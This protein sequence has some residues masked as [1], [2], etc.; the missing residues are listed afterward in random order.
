MSPSNKEFLNNMAQV[1]KGIEGRIAEL[2]NTLR[3][4]V[5]MRDRLDLQHTLQVNKDLLKAM[6]EEFW[7]ELS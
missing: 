5:I 3:K 4:D 6:K 2:E 7:G 1:M